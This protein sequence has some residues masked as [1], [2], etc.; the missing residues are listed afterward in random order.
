MLPIYL[1]WYQSQTSFLAS[2]KH[3]YTVK[4]IHICIAQI[5]SAPYL[6]SSLDSTA[7]RSHHGSLLC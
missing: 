6:T 7:S 4:K 1:T 5:H 3:L 2:N